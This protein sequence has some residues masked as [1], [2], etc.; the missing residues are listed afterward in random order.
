MKKPCTACEKRRQAM[1]AAAKKII[2]KIKL[3]G[4][5]K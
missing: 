3:K 2:V 5:T 1:L 4:K